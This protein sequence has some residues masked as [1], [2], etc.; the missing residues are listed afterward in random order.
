[1]L[2]IL[3]AISSPLNRIFVIA[4]IALTLGLS[5]A[6]WLSYKFYGNYAK[7]QT[8]LEYLKQEYDIIL[9]ERDKAVKA[10]QILEDSVEKTT[11]SYK[12]LSDNMESIR[13]NLR[14]MKSNSGCTNEE[15]DIDGKLPVDAIRLLNESYC[16]QAEGG[17]D[18]S[19][20]ALK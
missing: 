7:S 4:I 6:V 13:S 1:M 19:S 10:T 2:A 9:E 20:E 8:E 11:K 15:F 18:C 14:N 16:V 3:K 12:Q 5:G 17:G